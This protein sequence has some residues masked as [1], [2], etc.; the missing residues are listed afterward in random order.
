ML[1]TWM[2]VLAALVYLVALFAVAHLGEN[3]GRQLLQGQLRP[4]IYAL[5][6]GVYCTSWTFLGSVGLSSRTG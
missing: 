1:Q 6:L 3:R 4:V 2:A 5:T